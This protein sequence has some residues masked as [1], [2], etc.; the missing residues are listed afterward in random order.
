VFIRGDFSVGQT[1]V[2]ESAFAE[3]QNDRQS[4]AGGFQVIQC[5]SAIGV[6]DSVL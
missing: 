2:F 6:S 1:F 5:L 4:V 3:I